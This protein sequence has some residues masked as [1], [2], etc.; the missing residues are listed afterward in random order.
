MA[1]VFGSSRTCIEPHGLSR[2][3]KLACCQIVFVHRT[4]LWNLYEFAHK[5]TA[6]YSFELKAKTLLG[7]GVVCFCLLC[8][9]FYLPPPKKKH[10]ILV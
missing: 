5:D 1:V 10:N 6:E 7:E 2:H 4:H 3:L 9:L 8:S